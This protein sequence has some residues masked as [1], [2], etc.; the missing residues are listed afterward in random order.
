MN[1]QNRFRY[2]KGA[3]N[4][5]GDNE[6]VLLATNTK[7]SKNTMQSKVLVLREKDP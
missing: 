3:V 1:S 7:D 5:A 2:L 6:I 4:I